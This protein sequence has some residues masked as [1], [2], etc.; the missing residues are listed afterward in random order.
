M[1]APQTFAAAKNPLAAPSQ[2]T[3][4]PLFSAVAVYGTKIRR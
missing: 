3:F 1:H 4:H 2:S